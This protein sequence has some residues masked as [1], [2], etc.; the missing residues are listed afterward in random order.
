MIENTVLFVD[1]QEE[2]LFLIKRM[3]KDEP[4]KVLFANSGEEAL[5]VIKNNEIDVIVTDVIMPN[6]SGLELLEIVKE[7]HP[8][9]VRI[10]L[11]GFSQI[12]TLLSAI[13]NGKIFRYITKPWQVDNEAKGIIHDA[14]EYSRLIK[15]KKQD[16]MI[17]I[18]SF[19]DF[20]SQKGDIF[21]LAI[22]DKVVKAH[23]DLSHQVKLNENFDSESLALNKSFEEYSLSSSIKLY[24]QA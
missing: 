13:N 9:M 2:I 10:I 6:M 12:P 17:S 20:L 21:V 11:S 3:L 15:A 19:C 23:S 1:D 24:L 5:E 14:I 18:D 4:Y 8:D 7:S 22:N 16:K